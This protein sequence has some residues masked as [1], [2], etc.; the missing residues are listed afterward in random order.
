MKRNNKM[1]SPL[2]NGEGWNVGKI[3]KDSHISGF[4]GHQLKKDLVNT[5]GLAVENYGKGEII[6]MS[7]SPVFRGFWH[8]GELILGNAIFFVGQ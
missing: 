2:E 7:D 4:V 6:Y 3:K 1:F 5:V 8:S